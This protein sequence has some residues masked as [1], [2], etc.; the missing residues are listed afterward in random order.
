LASAVEVAFTKVLTHR[1]FLPMAFPV[2]LNW[3]PPLRRYKPCSAK[4]QEI[5]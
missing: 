3:Q 4:K 2:P 5:M 1:L